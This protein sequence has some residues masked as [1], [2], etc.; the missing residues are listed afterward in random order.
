[1][2]T[3]TR[4]VQ[5]ALLQGMVSSHI[6]CHLSGAVLDIKSAVMVTIKGPNVTRSAVYVG[7]EYDRHIASKLPAMRAKGFTVEVIDGRELRK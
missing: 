2:D 4:A 7:T 1:M 3:L 5:R 6:T